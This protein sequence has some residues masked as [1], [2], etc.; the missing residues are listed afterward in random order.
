MKKFALSQLNQRLRQWN[1]PT[2][3]AV[4]PQLTPDR[5][6]AVRSGPIPFALAKGVADEAQ[7]PPDAARHIAGATRSAGFGGVACACSLKKAA[8]VAKRERPRATVPMA[9]LLSRYPACSHTF[10]LNEIQ[11]LRQLGFE[12]VTASIN[13]S[14]RPSPELEEAERREEEKTFYVKRGGFGPALR[15]LVSA[16]V[17]RPAG[18]F[19]GLYFTAWL[20]GGGVRFFYFLEALMVG[21]WMLRHGRSHLHA[22]F[23]GP[24][25]SVAM[26]VARTFPVTMSFT[27]H[28]PD[29]FYDVE[30]FCLRQKIQTASFVCC[31][32]SYA[33]SQLM[34]FTPAA[35]WDK[36]LVSRLGVDCEKFS[37]FHRL[38]AAECVEIV[39]V[40]RLVPAKGQH[41]LLAAVGR[42]LDGGRNIRLRLVGDGPERGNLEAMVAEHGIG[43]RIVFEGAVGA[44]RVR[45]IL[46]GA[47]IFALPSFAEGIPVALMEAMAMEIPCVST[48]ITGIPEL[49]RHGVDGLLVAPCE[50]GQLTAALVRLIDDPDQRRRLGMAG[51]RRVAEEFDLQRNA[52]KLGEIFQCRL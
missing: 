36:L 23:G 30:K 38:V 35:E 21:N 33:R 48:T 24:V 25:A 40:G 44:S 15:A 2:T 14:D 19:R 13:P 27:V 39:C 18:V 45:T 6:T 51:R 32:S 22:H 5:R 1:V 46:A 20:G 37:P 42:L 12:I 52:K 26:I 50:V 3:P 4:G 16:L 10:L 34:M 49:I 43:G 9:Y 31:I 17:Q 7:E 47:D 28:G 29:E 11:A 41:I 8:P